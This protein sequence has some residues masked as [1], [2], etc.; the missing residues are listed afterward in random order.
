MIQC[1]LIFVWSSIGGIPWVSV[2]PLSFLDGIGDRSRLLKSVQVQRQQTQDRPISLP[3][4]GQTSHTFYKAVV[5]S[6]I[7]HD[8][9]VVNYTRYKHKRI[10]ICTSLWFSFLCLYEPNIDGVRMIPC[11]APQSVDFKPEMRL[12]ISCFHI[13]SDFRFVL[14]QQHFSLLP[15]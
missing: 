12:R 8:K 7:S 14:S 9:L 6:S 10:P 11:G 2:I 1:N 3:H 4:E 13:S 5:Y 15:L